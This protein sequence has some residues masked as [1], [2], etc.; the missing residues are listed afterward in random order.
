V[1]ALEGL[2]GGQL[3]LVVLGVAGDAEVFKGVEERRV[4]HLD[5]VRDG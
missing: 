5:G 2:C 1:R 4:G 3:A